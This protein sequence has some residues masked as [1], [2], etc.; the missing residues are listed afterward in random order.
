MN[1]PP[2]TTIPAGLASTTSARLPAISTYPLIWL[3]AVLLTWLTMMRAA[4]PALKF[5]L[6]LI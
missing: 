5:G 2:S 6:P 4:C 1:P 3:A